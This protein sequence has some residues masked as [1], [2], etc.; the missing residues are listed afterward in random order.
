MRKIVQEEGKHRPRHRGPS[1][2]LTY[3]EILGSK[4]IT[5]TKGK[6]YKKRMLQREAG[7]R[8]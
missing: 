4:Y 5:L 3:G 7:T 8:A 6:R 2:F 1:S